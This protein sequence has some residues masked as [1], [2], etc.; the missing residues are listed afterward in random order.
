MAELCFLF[1]ESD[2]GL[3]LKFLRLLKAAGILLQ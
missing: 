2:A 3:S 1:E